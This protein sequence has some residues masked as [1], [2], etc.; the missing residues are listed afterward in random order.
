MTKCPACSAPLPFGAIV[1]HGAMLG[2]PHYGIR[3]P[4]CRRYVYVARDL[5]N[6]FLPLA[7]LGASFIA[8][9]PSPISDQSL[10][11]AGRW[12]PVA[13]AEIWAITIF[14]A[15]ALFVFGGRLTAFPVDRARSR[16]TVRARVTNGVLQAIMLVWLYFIWRGLMGMGHEG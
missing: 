6:T 9:F 10:S 13:R 3:C 2:G 11:W 1:F 12:V 8:T 7:M 15:L 16:A 14:V 4:S 5:R